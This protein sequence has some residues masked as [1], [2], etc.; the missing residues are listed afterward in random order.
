M[1]DFKKEIIILEKEFRRIIKS[2]E[3]EKIGE[4]DTIEYYTYIS[5]KTGQKILVIAHCY[6]DFNTDFIAEIEMNVLG[7]IIKVK[8]II[9]NETYILENNIEIKLLEDDIYKNDNNCDVRYRALIKDNKIYAFQE[10][11]KIEE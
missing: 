9:N 6:L 11:L 3:M 4:K 7:N 1:E 2:L 10:L 8:N 5:K